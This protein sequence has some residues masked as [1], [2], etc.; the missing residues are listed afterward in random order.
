[1]TAFDVTLGAGTRLVFFDLLAVGGARWPA[2]EGI[3]VGPVVG[4]VVRMHSVIL[5]L[6]LRAEVLPSRAAF[7]TIDLAPFGLLGSL[8]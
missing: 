8:L 2:V 3:E 1:M 5:G 7:L 6:G 4:G